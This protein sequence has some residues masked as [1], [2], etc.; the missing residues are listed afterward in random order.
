MA[1]Q[2]KR[3][4][5]RIQLIVPPE[6][7]AAWLAN[8]AAQAASV[9]S[10]HSRDS[11]YLTAL[12]TV[13]ARAAPPA[14][15]DTASVHS[16]TSSGND[17]PNIQRRLSDAVGDS[18]SVSSETHSAHALQTAFQNLQTIVQTLTDKLTDQNHIIEGLRACIKDLCDRQALVATVPSASQAPFLTSQQEMAPPPLTAATQPTTTATQPTTAA[19]PP[20][21]AMAP[22]PQ[23]VAPSPRTW[24]S[25]TSSGPHRPAP[26]SN[27]PRRVS[28]PRARCAF[29]AVGSQSDM[30]SLNGLR[31]PDLSHGLASLLLQRLSLPPGALRIVDAYP[32]G[33]TPSDSPDSR[34]RLFFRVECPADADLIVRN[35]HVLKDS[36]LTIFDDL[37][38]AERAAHRALWPIFTNARNMGLKAQFKRAKLY[39]TSKS[40]PYQVVL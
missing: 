24:A 2:K 22:Q 12:D 1:K 35:R 19:P 32:L 39:I 8:R 27:P 6:A 26:S 34:R 23:P 29:T 11:N 31:G 14:D 28:P 37:S 25:V 3:S 13:S 17:R 10:K 20:M 33:R 15:N 5:Q 40:T 38:S 7:E 30:S 36:Q 4:S 18:I 21:T 9:G 16:A